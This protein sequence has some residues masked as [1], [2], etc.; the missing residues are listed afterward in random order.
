MKQPTSNGCSNGSE[1]QS[2]D[3][4]EEE[5]EEGE[6]QAKRPTILIL[7]LERQTTSIIA[8]LH[9]YKRLSMF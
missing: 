2:G 6:G 3:T 4:S 1:E 5:E 8:L 7:E 9:R